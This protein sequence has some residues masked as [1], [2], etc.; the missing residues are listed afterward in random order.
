[1][2]R[3]KAVTSKSKTP[4]KRSVAKKSRA[5]R[6]VSHE[7]AFSEPLP[8]V[9]LAHG[10]AVHDHSAAFHHRNHRKNQL[11]M[12]LGIGVI[13]TGLIVAWILNLNRLIGG[14]ADAAS[15][16]TKSNSSAEFSTL[17]QELSSTLAEVKSGIEDLKQ[18]E[19]APTST[20]APDTAYPT[21]TASPTVTQPAVPATLP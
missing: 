17:R 5:T 11:I 12:S 18:I 7:A 3:T 19:T 21:D 13:M 14:Q 16:E 20:T 9:S 1:M 2:P 8:A 15:R 4:R 6:V 10:H